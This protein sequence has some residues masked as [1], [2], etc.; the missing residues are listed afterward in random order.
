MNKKYTPI[1]Y[2]GKLLGELIVLRGE[3]FRCRIV[4]EALKMKNDKGKYFLTFFGMRERYDNR[5]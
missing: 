2:Q 4:T 5:N 1:Q 3:K